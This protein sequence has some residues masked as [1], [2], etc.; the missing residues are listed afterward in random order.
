M[1][2]EQKTEWNKC[3]HSV[4]HFVRAYC[5]IYNA[6]SK[7][8]VPFRLWQAQVD[9]L[10]AFTQHDKII[11]LKARQLGLSWLTLCYLLW[12]MLFHPAAA[13]LIFS[14]RD[15]E[16]KALLCERLK[17]IHGLLPSWMQQK[18][19]TSND[20]TWTMANGSS[21]KAFPTT[22]G[23]SYTGSYVLMDEADFM[24]KFGTILDAVQPTIDAGGQ[25]III[26]TTDKTKP[27]SVFK[28][29]FNAAVEGLTE[30][31][32]IFLPWHARPSRTPQ[33]YEARR[34]DSLAKDGTTDSLFQEY[35]A[36]V[37]EALAP[38]TLDKRF[39]PSFLTAIFE[40]WPVL[41]V[42]P[43]LPGLQIYKAVRP[44]IKYCIG[45]DPAEGNPNSDDSAAIVL[46][47][48]TGEECARL[49]G[50]FEPGV[51]AGYIDS[52]GS[53]FNKAPV[54]VERNNHGH[55][56][57]L[58]L[59]HT[60]V[61]RRLFGRDGHPGWLNNLPGK[62]QMYDATAETIRQ[63]AKDGKRVLHSK[64]TFQQLASIEGATL[65]APE[66][67]L[68]DLADSYCLAEVARALAARL[69]DQAKQQKSVT[70]VS[71]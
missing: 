59:N 63:N 20:H 11:T 51:F 38:N 13:V 52:L 10:R 69:P 66:G 12:Q 61:L 33:W 7:Q 32:P 57:L 2:E 29:M 16:A 67:Q 62:V 49:R 71:L 43:S 48:D 40:Q 3:A 50:K 22:G 25:M 35:P 5:M 70:G 58:A 15:E 44:G 53:W 37:E 24:D 60:K 46:E 23:R 31:H 6:T 55:A 27:E 64:D 19:R 9:T 17:E 30:Y 8:W 39:P 4:S 28:R 14:K 45:A 42:G 68:D 41:D 1:T 26:S 34:Q 56:V 18:I 54:L 36:T 47:V 21:A 65:A